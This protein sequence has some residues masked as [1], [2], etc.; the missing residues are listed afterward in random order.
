VLA[1]REN[2]PQVWRA[3]RIKELYGRDDRGREEGS[4]DEAA[5]APAAPGRELGKAAPEAT[6]S[7]AQDRSNENQSNPGTGWGE[8]GYDPVQRARFEAV[9]YASDQIVLR[10]EYASGL[11]ALGINPWQNRNRIWE[12]ERGELGFAQPPNR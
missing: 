8:R 11:R 4:R 5:P 9:P 7:Y 3:P 12:R 2:E 6:R 1:F 10:Y